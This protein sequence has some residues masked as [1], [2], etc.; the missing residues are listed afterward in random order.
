MSD[1]ISTFLRTLKASA[2]EN[3]REIE[4]N[5]VEIPPRRW[6]APTFDEPEAIARKLPRGLAVNSREGPDGRPFISGTGL[7]TL[8][9]NCFYP[10]TGLPR[11]VAF[12]RHLAASY[13][14]SAPRKVLAFTD[15]ANNDLNFSLAYE[16]N[17]AHASNRLEQ[18]AFL[19]KIASRIAGEDAADPL[20]DLWLTIDDIETLLEPLDFGPILRMG[21]VLARWINRPF[22]PFPEELDSTE[23]GY[24]RAFL[25]QAKGDVQANDLADI[26]GMRMFSGWGARMLVERT[27]ERILERLE[28]SFPLAEAAGQR[29][30]LTRLKAL[31]C[32][33]RTCRNAVA[34][35]AQLDRVNEANV[36]PDPDP[37]LGTKATW[38]RNDLLR[39]AREEIHNC[40]ELKCVLS[41]AGDEH[42]L[43]T[44]S[45]PQEET[46]MRLG[47]DL[48][49]QLVRKTEIMFEHW[50][51][52]DRLFTEPNV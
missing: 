18:M 15:S 5:L 52:Y 50:R 28:T 10:L 45:S 14:H 21:C 32:L 19:R 41:E 51:D 36:P 26:Q 39:I 3:G 27:I 13:R 35:Q 37:V 48:Q 11:P 29:K 46:I 49:T 1:R 17:A 34:Y 25:F 12:L 33:I 38:A 44:A 23:S 9:G 7:E 40:I 31:R 8:W 30:T 20:L 42:V 43:D 4:L 16:F 2:E 22:V 47:P 6:M 24:W